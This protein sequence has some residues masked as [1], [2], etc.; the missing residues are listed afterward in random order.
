MGVY[1]GTQW[2][3]AQ[4]APDT[5][6]IDTIRTQT[7]ISDSDQRRI[8]EWIEAQV[9]KLKTLPDD[10]RGPSAIKLREL[11]RTQFENAGNSAAFKDQF[12]SRVVA[13]AVAQLGD[14]GTNPRTGQTLCKVLLDLNRP[15]A[16]AAFLVG[17]KSKDAGVRMLSASGLAAHR[18]I[19]VADKARL[20]QAIAALRDAGLAETEGV[21]LDRMYW[22]LA[23]PPTQVASVFDAFMAILDQRLKKRREGAAASDGA[24]ISALEF[25]RTSGVIGALSQPQKEQLARAVATFMRLDAQ[26]YATPNLQFSEIDR[27]QRLLD[28]AEEILVALVGAGKGGDVRGALAGGQTPKQVLQQ[29][30]AWVGDANQQGALNA[31][32]WN[33]PAGAP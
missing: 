27:L 10:Q 8:G 22:A 13:V 14:S 28:G 26:R 29:V 1:S 19:L 18:A 30:H 12:A 2:C 17:L 21:A 25:F 20:D 31:A 5:A 6:I 4:G 23:V 33:V 24:E 9:N 32:P 16:V 15:E 3:R 11:L 7:Q